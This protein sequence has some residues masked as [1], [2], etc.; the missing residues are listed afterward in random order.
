VLLKLNK[1]IDKS[2]QPDGLSLPMILYKAFLKHDYD[3][4]GDFHHKALFIGLMHFMDLYNYD[5]ERV[6]RCNI[7]YTSPDGR[8]LPFCA[9]NVIPEWYRDKIQREYGIPIP[10]WEKKTG[11]RLADDLYKQLS[12]E[13]SKKRIVEPVRA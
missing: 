11:R 8:I 12:T 6:R 1:F 9:F 10:E 2:K 7:H 13:E 5:I 4:L 3:S